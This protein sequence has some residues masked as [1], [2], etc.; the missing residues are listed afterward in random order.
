[1]GTTYIWPY[2]PATH[3]HLV[4]PVVVMDVAPSSLNVSRP[5]MHDTADRPSSLMESEGLFQR[6]RFIRSVCVDI[7]L[8]QQLGLVVGG[9]AVCISK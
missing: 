3:T 2:G 5:L 9:E 4:Q 8:V 6:N 7:G 1:M